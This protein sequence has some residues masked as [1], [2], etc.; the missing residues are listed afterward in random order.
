VAIVAAG[1]IW[2]LLARRQQWWPYREGAR[3]PDR[4][5]VRTP[6]EIRAQ[7]R[8]WPADGMIDVSGTPGERLE[9]VHVKEG[10][11]VTKGK[12]LATLGSH[13]LRQQE[14]DLARQQVDEAQARH[15]AELK[16]AQRRIELAELSHRQAHDKF[17][18]EANALRQK[19]PLLELSHKLAQETLNRLN[20]AGF[21]LVPQIEKERQELL[22][23]QAQTDLES[24]K[25]SLET[26]ERSLKRQQESA[27]LELATL[28][29]AKE[30]FEKDLTVR[31]LQQRLEVA[32]EQLKLTQ[33]TAPTDGTVLRVLMDAGDTIVAQPIL[34]M[35][36]LDQMTVVAEVVQDYARHLQPH[37]TKVT[38]SS[39]IFGKELLH[40]KLTRVGHLVSPPDIKDPN[41]F[42]QQD[43]R[44][45]EVVIELDRP[46]SSR[47][48][49]FVNLQVEVKFEPPFTGQP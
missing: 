39:P 29:E 32:E 15:D 26:L 22:V 37:Q 42:S 6:N 1:A 20:N 7:G 47:A 12:E 18:D 36:N 28:E 16:A 9:A 23:L 40:G 49:K 25:K 10:D 4:E 34:Q 8:I 13:K 19:L 21:D 27:A 5:A 14:R 11:T 44:V 38:I 48:A 43:R 31:V 3:L 46:S 2:L 33:L 17:M 30:R 24:A 41:P 45:V 35:A